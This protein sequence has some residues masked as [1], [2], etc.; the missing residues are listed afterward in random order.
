[1]L[2][3]NRLLKNLSHPERKMMEKSRSAC[4]FFQLIGL[5]TIVTVGS[6]LVLTP[7]AMADE[8]VGCTGADG[9]KRGTAAVVASQ[10]N[11][12]AGTVSVYGSGEA[13]EARVVAGT[14]IND[15]SGCTFPNSLTKSWRVVDV[16]TKMMVYKRSNSGVYSFCFSRDW[17]WA[18]G[19]NYRWGGSANV[20][21]ACGW[22]T[23]GIKVEGYTKV[24]LDDGSI[25]SVTVANPDP[26]R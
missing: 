18:G 15:I 13:S 26:K 3:F 19:Y 1:M 12:S 14:K 9:V 6:S 21:S 17:G 7:V 5:G 23:N 4:K 24:L 25:V 20:V 2:V 11:P 10:T 8:I 22:N 16:Y